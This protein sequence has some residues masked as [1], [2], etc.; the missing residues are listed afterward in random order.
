MRQ[1]KFETPGQV[2]VLVDNKL[3]DV[4]LSTHASPTTE[5]DLRADGARGDQVVEDVRVEHEG[6]DGK[7]RVVVEVPY[8]LGF[9][10]HNSVAV[11]VTVR[12]PEGAL[13]DVETISGKVS[14]KGYLG[15]AKVSTTSGN[16]SLGSVDGDVVVHSVSGD[17]T[18]ESVTGGTEVATASGSVRCRALKK[19][20]TV[21]TVSGDIDVASTEARVTI[22]TSSGDVSA[23][24]LEDGCDMKTV[25][26]DQRV[27][28]L[29]AGEAEFKTV[30]GSMTIA[31][32]RGTAVT[33]DAESL[34]GALSSE[35]EL[36]TDEPDG[37]VP[38]EQAGPH[39]EVRARTVSG[40]VRIKRASV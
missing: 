1:E 5:V 7:Q 2:E 24:E 12:L 39:A 3:G 34:S 17:V 10:R 13:I 30:S 38:D 9:L 19:A 29:V 20:G 40:D 23:G 8:E 36:S 21:R 22:E 28:R 11:T 27:R 4:R 35:I 18:V 15:G 31:V 16:V 25:S 14:G 26:G 37:A 6:F 33:I 32:A